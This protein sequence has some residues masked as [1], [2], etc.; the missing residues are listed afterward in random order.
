MLDATIALVPF[1]QRQLSPFVPIASTL[2]CVNVIDATFYVNTDFAPYDARITSSHSNAAN[3][4]NSDITNRAAR[5]LDFWLRRVGEMVGY[6]RRK[7]WIVDVP[8][9]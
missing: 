7:R 3:Y 9:K 6:L 4:T 5:S 2:S 1:G 8:K